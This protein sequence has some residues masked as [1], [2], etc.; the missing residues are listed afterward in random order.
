MI[1]VGGHTP[2]KKTSRPHLENKNSLNLDN[3]KL[4]GD[5]GFSVQIEVQ[6]QPVK[7][8]IDTGATITLLSS[9]MYQQ[10]G[11]DCRPQLEPVTYKLSMADGNSTL[12]VQ[13]QG[14]FMIKC[15]DTK[16]KHT[17]VVANIIGDGLLGMDFLSRHVSEINVK[18]KL[19]I[20]GNDKIH[21]TTKYGETK[22]CCL[23]S[24]QTTSIPAGHEGIIMTTIQG[25]LQ[26]IGSEAIVEPNEKFLQRQGV[27]VGHTLVDATSASIPVRI[28][29]LQDTDV[30]VHANTKVGHLDFVDTVISEEEMLPE[31]TQQVNEIGKM[32]PV[33]TEL[34]QRSSANLN[35]SEANALASML[36]RCQKAFSLNGE[37]GVTDIV[38]HKINTGD[39][40]PIRQQFRRLPEAQSREASKQ[41]KD[42][43]EKGIIEPSQSPWSSPIVLVKRKDSTFRFCCDYRKLNEV[44]IKDAYPLPRINDMLDCLSGSSYFST[45]DL[46]SG[47]WQ[48]KTDEKDKNKTAF[49]TRDGLFNFHVL[50]FGVANGPACFERLMETVLAGLQ[51]KRC[52]VYLDDIIVFGKTFDEHLSRL[53]EVLNRLIKAGLK[54]KVKKCHM[55][56]AQ[57][58][59]LGFVVSPNGVETDYNKIKE[60]REWPVP[61][62]VTQVKSFLGLC[63][64]YRRFVRG[65]SQIAAP[66]NRLTQKDQEFQWTGECQLAFDNLKCCLTKA[67]VLA[68]PDFK[69]EFILDTDASNHSVGAVL[70]QVQDGEERVIAYASRALNKHEKKYCVT[71]KELLAAVNFI[72]YFRNYLYGRPFILRV[73]HSALRWIRNFKEPEGQVARWLEILGTYD[74][75]I[76]HRPGLKHGNADGMSRKPCSQCGWEDDKISGVLNPPAA[77]VQNISTSI[78]DEVLTGHNEREYRQ[79]QLNDP[80][81]GKI[82]QLKES[83]L[84][85][86]AWEEVSI[87]NAEFKAYWAK[88]EQLVVQNGILFY[89]WIEMPEES[90]TYRLLV[91]SEE[92]TKVC[93]HLH[94]AKTAGHLGQTRTLEKI[95][96]RF[97]WY[98][99]TEFIQEYCAA[100]LPCASRKTTNHR[101]KAPLQKYIVGVPMERVALDIIGPLPRTQRG[102]MFCLVISDYFTKWTECYPMRKIDAVTTAKLFVEQFVCRFGLPRQVHTDRGSNFTSKL[103]SQM[104]SLLQIDK[105]QTTSYHAMGDGLV[106]RFNRTL[107]EML[108]LFVNKNQKNWDELLPYLLLAYRSSKHTSTGVTPSKMML[109]RD[110][111]LPIDLI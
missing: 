85:Q 50:P 2:V 39:A 79:L 41:I 20:I 9:K 11:K 107:E 71:R 25:E 66:L 81:I 92:R 93:N 31:E 38:K 86:P 96:S 105:T 17:L 53:E 58:E 49:I 3:V 7:F 64:Y 63:S 100:C 104:C 65:F 16:M 103:F 18:E 29:N 23:I 67:P 111:T 69:Q 62:N 37:L 10:L 33:L 40:V 46:R 51:W 78:S 14:Q 88:W 24:K 12:E 108:S 47:Y 72:K 102:H 70:S 82:L 97:Y 83:K 61:T 45:L 110:V 74:F 4:S 101:L 27:L 109:G 95:K 80:V 89:K 8:S 54:L 56:K 99:M 59:F 5:I 76:Q 94:D 1:G 57:V 87:E 43:L 77:H 34:W 32:H 35:E 98:K 68:Y 52:L 106:E 75:K 55:L 21:M 19:I 13:G 73:D 36:V 15:G 84:K 6:G 30:T 90:I 26:P 42:M 28:C 48:V 91:P 22:N 60:V 44:T